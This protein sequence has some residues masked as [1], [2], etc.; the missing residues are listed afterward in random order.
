MFDIHGGVHILQF[1]SWQLH[2]TDLELLCDACLT[3]LGFW[4]PACYEEF[5]A[6]LPVLPN[7]VEDTIFRYESL[8]VLAALQWAVSLHC[9]PQHLA[10]DTNNLNTVQI[11]DSFKASAS[12]NSTLHVASVILIELGI[13]LHVWHIFGAENVVADALSPG[14]LPVAQFYALGLHISPF[15]PLQLT[16]GSPKK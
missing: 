2:D 16:S 4:S 9:R 8:C 1:L 3:S 7:H 11:F 5:I 10:I 12:Y 6:M 15:S 13:D 14:M